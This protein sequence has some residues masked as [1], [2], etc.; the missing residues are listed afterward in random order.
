[1]RTT[2]TIDDDVVKAL[3]ERSHRTGR[4]FKAVVNE[5]LLAGLE[6]S[7][8]AHRPRPYRLEPASLGGVRSDV[9]LDKALSLADSLEDREIARKLAQRK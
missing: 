4:S 8:A 2:L 3:K 5:V 7:D 1:V 9:D 6:A